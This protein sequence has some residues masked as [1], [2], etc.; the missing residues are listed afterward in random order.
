MESL[1]LL[2]DL[3]KLAAIFARILCGDDRFLAEAAIV[4]FYPPD[5]S[6]GPHTDHS[7]PDQEAPLIS[8]SLGG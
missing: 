3:G 2:Q 8:I 6:L 1:F 4:N 7:E 5:S